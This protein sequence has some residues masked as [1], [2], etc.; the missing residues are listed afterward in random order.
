MNEN[1][2]IGIIGGG[3]WGTAIV[4]MLG[5]NVD[6]LNWWMQNEDAIKHIQ[7]FGHNPNYISDAEL[8]KNK[9]NISVS[10]LFNYR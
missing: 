9:L 1:S 2:K 3:S 5:E 7:K 6:A 8:K 10:F 4:K